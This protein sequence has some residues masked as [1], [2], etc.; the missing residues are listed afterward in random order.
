MVLRT[1]I[2]FIYLI[3]IASLPVIPFT[4]EKL[5]DALHLT[6]DERKQLPTELLALDKLQ[7]NRPFDVP[8]PLF[9]KIDDSEVLALSDQYGGV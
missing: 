4:S 3:A 5:F 8:P 1:A 2:N 7:A 9:R 6:T